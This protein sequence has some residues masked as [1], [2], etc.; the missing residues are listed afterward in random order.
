M[1]SQHPQAGERELQM[2]PVETAHNFKIGL[3]ET[4]L[5]SSRGGSEDTG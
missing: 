2:Q 5:C 3:T 4:L 1:T